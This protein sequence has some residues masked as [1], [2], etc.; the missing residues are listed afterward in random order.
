MAEFG[1]YAPDRSLEVDPDAVRSAH[2]EL[3]RLGDNH[4]FFHPRFVG[5]TGPRDR[6]H[7][8]SH[9]T[10]LVRSLPRLTR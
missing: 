10:G 8:D 4:P 2:A 5:Q 3:T 9:Q 1:P 7:C 6:R